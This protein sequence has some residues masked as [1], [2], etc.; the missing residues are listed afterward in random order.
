M[1]ILIGR[2]S[3]ILQYYRNQ[4]LTTKRKLIGSMY[5]KN[6]YYDGRLHRT[7][8]ESEPLSLILLINSELEYIKK[9]EK[10]C[11]NSFSPQVARRGI[12]PLFL[13]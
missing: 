10:L 6:L 3:N 7:L 9:G 8:F 5:P 12:E 4:D 2:F 11:L 13:E 1:D